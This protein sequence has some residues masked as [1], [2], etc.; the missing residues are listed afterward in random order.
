MP[1]LDLASLVPA[2]GTFHDAMCE[3]PSTRKVL[4]AQAAEY[5]ESKRQ[6]FE[7]FEG[8]VSDTMALL[9][10]TLAGLFGHEV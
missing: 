4:A 3:R 8:S 10:P 9:R 1:N 6:I 2:L 7:E 5:E